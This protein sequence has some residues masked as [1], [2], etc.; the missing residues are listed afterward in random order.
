MSIQMRKGNERS[1]TT[2]TGCRTSVRAMM[3]GASIYPRTD[4]LALPTPTILGGGDVIKVSIGGGLFIECRVRMGTIEKVAMVSMKAD[5]ITESESTTSA[6]SWVA[7]RPAEF[8]ALI[9]NDDLLGCCAWL[10]WAVTGPS[11]VSKRN[12]G[13]LPRL[14]LGYACWGVDEAVVER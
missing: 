11:Y 12:G 8:T 13:K 10:C 9:V 14:V 1:S 7:P 2:I 5:L 6:K 3:I 4:D